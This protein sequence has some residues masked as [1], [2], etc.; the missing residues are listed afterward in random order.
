MHL[1]W[2]A[3][4]AALKQNEAFTKVPSKYSD[5]PNVFSFD[6]VIELLKNTGINEH[7]I[8]LQDGKQL[9]YRSIYGLEPIELETLKTYIETHLQTGF[10]WPFKPSVGAPILF[11]K[12]SNSSF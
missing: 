7:V 10:I 6:L 1:S 4:I 12:K 5:Y 11:D 9:P 8:E 3:Q 2:I